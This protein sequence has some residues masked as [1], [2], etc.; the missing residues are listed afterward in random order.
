MR[1]LV[2]D[3]RPF[4]NDAL[5]AAVDREHRHGHRGPAHG[6]GGAGADLRRD[7]VVGVRRA[8]RCLRPGAARRLRALRRRA[9]RRLRSP[10]HAHL[11]DGGADRHQHAVLGAGRHGWR[12]RLAAAV[13]LRGATGVL[14]G[15][16]ADPQ[17]RTPQAAPARPAP[18]RQLAQH[19]GVDG[20]RHR[21]A[22]GGRRADPGDRPR[23]ALPHRQLQPAGHARRRD[24]AAAAA[25]RGRRLAGPRAALGRGGLQLSAHP[26]GADDVVRRRHHR[27]DLRDAAGAVPPDRARELP[28]RRRR[29]GSRSRCSSPPSQRVR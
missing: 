24:P 13:P 26:A 1:G 16:P 5:Q 18:R 27:D 22:V 4:Q 8:H 2:A 28:R 23:V 21:R 19:D 17:R 10:D 9:G 29:E 15:Q 12:Q 25:D 14:R 7:R 11:H 20:R 3:T 6:G